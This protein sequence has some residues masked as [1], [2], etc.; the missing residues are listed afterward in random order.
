MACLWLMSTSTEL[1]T[2]ELE[3]EKSADLEHE[4]TAVT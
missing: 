2:T 4:R 3:T 1:E